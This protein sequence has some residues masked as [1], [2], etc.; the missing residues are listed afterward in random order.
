MGGEV[1]GPGYAKDDPA[2][3]LQHQ[4]RSA[5]NFAAAVQLSAFEHLLERQL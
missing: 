1:D 2:G 5:S 4:L 3:L